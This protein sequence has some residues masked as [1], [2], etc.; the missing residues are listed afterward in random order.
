[1][2]TQTPTATSEG[3]VKPSTLREAIEVRRVR[4]ERFTMREAVAIIVPLSTHVAALH[5]E[6]KKLLLHPSAITHGKAGTEVDLA[7]ATMPPAHARDKACIAPECRRGEAGDARA[8]VFSLG[9]ILYEL[10]TGDHVGPGMKRPTEADPRLPAQLEVVLGKAL[11]GDP[12]HR[13][14]DL[15][16]LAQAFHHLAP[17]GSMAPPA[18][19]ESHLDHDAGFDVDVSLSMI[20]PPPAMP[21]AGGAP[22]AA[23]QEGAFVVATAP[24]SSAR[25]PLDPLQQLTALKA[26]L[27]SDPRPR[28]VVV[29]EGMDHGP[30]TAVEL[31][32]QIASHSFIGEHVLR[33]AISGDERAID[34]WEDFSLFAQQAQ[35]NRDIKQERKAL[36][37]VIKTERHRAQWKVLVGGTL[38]AVI[39]AG[40]VGWW[41]RE[42]SR[43][44]FDENVHADKA[45]VTDANA[46]LSAEKAGAAKGGSGHW[47]GGAGSFPQVSGGGSCEAAIAKYTEDYSQQ[48]VPPD[49]SAGAYAGVLNKGSYLNS[50]GV[51]SNMAVSICAAVQNGR[52]VGV[53]VVT[54]PSNPGISSCVRA[55]VMGLGFPSHP[56]MDVART[57]FAA[58]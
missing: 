31:L 3:A 23:R 12:K 55:Q 22:I 28:Y 36:D 14:S 10:V 7:A 35:L 44:K 32:Q 46:A 25:D 4:G 49:L 50:C 45:S 13:P 57:T 42:R 27:E 38:L 21:G 56:R 34:T 54:T 52:A 40:G 53:T 51:P 20:P 58:N 26:R 5:E 6:G 18:A 47:A 33:D 8:S 29:K 41:M 48:G 15:A 9:A 43:S 16:A 11:V 39:A 37:V 1:M 17:S 19:D 30:F 2:S 24:P